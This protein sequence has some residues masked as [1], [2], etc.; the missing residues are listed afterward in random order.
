MGTTGSRRHALGA[1]VLLLAVGVLAQACSDNKGSS[2]FPASVTG[3]PA[4]G[5]VVLVTANPGSIELG[6]ATTITVFV[7]TQTGV[8]IP[9]EPVVVSSDGGVLNP[10]SGVTDA[11][12][13]FTTTLSLPCQGG[14]PAGATT[15]TV[16]AF[17][18]GVLVAGTVNI[19][20][21]TANTPCD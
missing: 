2:G 6:R 18:Q 20:A 8:P 5:G 10:T 11:N 17:V 9:G 7:T 14:V 21:P 4:G 1:L 13:R 16:T 19:A 15:V 3:S 12:G